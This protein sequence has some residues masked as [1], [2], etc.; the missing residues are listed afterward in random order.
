MP[1]VDSNAIMEIRSVIQTRNTEMCLGEYCLRYPY[2][3]F[4]K[5]QHE[6]NILLNN[7]PLEFLGFGFCFC[8]LKVQFRTRKLSSILHCKI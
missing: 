5:N 3:C 8:A 6:N 2:H 4:C 7:S 1:H